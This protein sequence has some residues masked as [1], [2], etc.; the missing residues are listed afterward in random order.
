MRD[1]T[2]PSVILQGDGIACPETTVP[3]LTL[4]DLHAILMR[5]GLYFYPA[6][7]DRPD[8]KLRLL[9]ECAP[10]AFLAD[11]AG[12]AATTGTE[13]ILD[14][15]PREIHQRVPFAIGSKHEIEIYEAAFREE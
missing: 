5:G 1:T 12:G 11:C 10:L 13:R 14:V 6:D 2:A 15:A 4:A 8:G 9:Y 3:V 7:R